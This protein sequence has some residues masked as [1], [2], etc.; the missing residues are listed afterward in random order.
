MKNSETKGGGIAGKILL[1]DDEPS[2][3][4]LMR[5]ILEN[6]GYQITEAENGRAALDAANAEPPDTVLLDVMMPE[7]D[8]FEACR[9]L[10]GNEQTQ[11]IPV[12]MVSALC[13]RKN[14]IEGISAG[15]TDFITKPIDM[16]DMLLR[17]G[18]AVDG[19]HLLDEIQANC[20]RLEKAQQERAATIKK[21]V[22]DMRSPLL[23][24][25]GNLELLKMIAG[26]KLSAEELSYLENSIGSAA[27]LVGQVDSLI[28]PEEA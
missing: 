2:N 15:A 27:A 23:G 13:D 5:D 16:H 11:H 6:S 25:S 10:K 12:L 19:K 17:V 7:M 4:F 18:H 26:E 3:R 1:V 20:E 21:I 28:E 24:I 14:R 8:G 22:H 9:R